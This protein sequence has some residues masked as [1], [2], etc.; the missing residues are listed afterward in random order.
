MMINNPLAFAGACIHSGDYPGAELACRQI[1]EWDPGIGEAWFVLGVASQLLGKVAESV[2]YYR[3]SVRLAPGNAEAWNNLG[4]ALIPAQVRGSGAVP[5]P[6]PGASPVSAGYNNLG[7]AS[8]GAVRRGP[9]FVPLPGHPL[10]AGLFRGLHLWAGPVPGTAG[11]AVDWFT[12]PQALERAPEMGRSA[13]NYALACLQTG[14][15]FARG[16]TDVCHGGFRCREHPVLGPGGRLGWITP[17]RPPILLWRAG[18]GD[19]I[20][21]I[22]YAG[23]PGSGAGRVIVACPRPLCGSRRRVQASAGAVPKLGPLRSHSRLPRRRLDE[24][25]LD[26]PRCRHRPGDHARP[27]LARLAESSA[28]RSRRSRRDVPCYPA[29]DPALDDQCCRDELRPVRRFQDRDCLEAIRSTRRIAASLVPARSLRA[30]GGYSRPEALRLQKGTCAGAAPRASGPPSRD[31]PGAGSTT[32]WTPP[33]G[34]AP[35]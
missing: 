9:G 30:S 21:F 2:T 27:S 20:Q 23:R 19:S 35:S 29:A 28:P 16:W 31:R 8:R 15:D 26:P 10:Q 25:A 34:P 4:F 33:G 5:A 7:N 22:R 14:R 32:S 18:T 11:R 12:R 13:A 6:G 1:L 24:L 3:N 17:A